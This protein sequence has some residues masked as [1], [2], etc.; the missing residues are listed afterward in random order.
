MKKIKIAKKGKGKISKKF[1]RKKNKSSAI[2]TCKDLI[3]IRRYDEEAGGFILEGGRYMDIL[4]IIPKD[5]DNMSE[6]ELKLEMMNLIKTFR[7]VGIDMKFT[8]INFPLNADMQKDILAY[9]GDSAADIVRKKWIERQINELER[10]ESGVQTRNFSLMFFGDNRDNFIKNKEI[11]QKYTQGGYRSQTEDI[12]KSEKVHILAKLANMNTIED[13]YRENTEKSEIGEDKKNGELFD[14]ALFS[15]LQPKGGVTFKNPSYMR[16]GDGYVRCLHVYE[17]PTYIS[18]Y[19]LISLFALHNCIC[20]FDVSSKNINEVKKNI[21]KSI[22]EE[23]ARGNVAKNYEEL[24]DSK[25]RSQELQ[26]LYDNLSRMGEVIKVCDF[27]IFIHARTLIELEER[28]SEISQNLEADSYKVTT[29]LNEQKTEWQSLFE[30]FKLTHGKNFVMKGL[31][32]T[33]EQLA[34]GLPFNYSELID[35]AGVLLGFTDIGGSVI[36]DPFTKT[37][38]RK[39][40]NSII[41]GNMGSGKSTH[42]KKMFKHQASIG[43]YVRTFDVSGEFTD[44]TLEFGGKIIKCN[45]K[46]GML[47]P[48]EILNAGD[49]DSESYAKHISKLQAFF[50]CINPSMS[51]ELLQELANQ[52]KN[53]YEIYNL[54]PNAIRKITGL[55]AE[56]YPIFSN[57]RLYLI[58]CISRL[59]EMDKEAIT[60]VET[61]LNIDKAK[62]LNALL[63]TV[64]NLINNYGNIFNGHTTIKDITTEKIVTFDISA[65]KSLG[66]IFAATMQNLVSLCWDNAVSNGKIM[67][68]KWESEDEDEKVSNEDITRFLVIIDEAHEWVNTKM[69]QILDMIIKYER[70]AR[71]YFAGIILASQSV[72]DFAPKANSEHMETIRKLFEFSQYKF[73]FQQDSSA[74]AHIKDI[75]GSNITYSQLEKIPFLETGEC[76]L[77]ISGDRSLIFREWLSPV[78]EEKLFAGGM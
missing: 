37:K 69:P 77:S 21:T 35:R 9:Y 39:Y 70:E 63:E 45:D 53:F 54:T 58:Q 8:S 47:N 28:T 19:W 3:P 73:M 5:L 33:S 50:K 57:F 76:V 38:K 71:K 20:T 14:K 48:L 12:S 22:Q 42:L 72:S 60:D 62:H 67:K 10:V 49:D 18:T 74:T 43:N 31:V 64:D 75:F 4:K 15:S 13:L 40:Y 25:K 52:L 32:L 1:E 65:I 55:G 17:L 26:A 46:E 6:D 2:K 16:F 44:L 59:V 27:R 34:I 23:T 24:Y 68:A 30:P 36:F 61:T 56:N 41:S 78:Y 7:T 11:V 29:L 51:D 66:N